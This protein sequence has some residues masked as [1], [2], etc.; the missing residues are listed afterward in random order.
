MGRFT[1]SELEQL[2]ASK[3]VVANVA[4]HLVEA[5]MAAQA[6]TKLPKKVKEKAEWLLTDAADLALVLSQLE[7]FKNP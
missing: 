2:D 1:A 5:Y 7:K 3:E 4:Q 6:S